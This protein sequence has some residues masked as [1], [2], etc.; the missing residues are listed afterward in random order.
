M[1]CSI[2]NSAPGQ[3]TEI[4]LL[5]ADKTVELQVCDECYE[6]FSEDGEINVIRV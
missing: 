6:D 2:C 4:E 3:M 1:E 5:W